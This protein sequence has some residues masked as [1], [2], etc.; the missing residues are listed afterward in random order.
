L[1]APVYAIDSIVRS[2]VVDVT[3]PRR[4]RSRCRRRRWGASRS[5]RWSSA[6]PSD[7][8]ATLREENRRLRE[9]IARLRAERGE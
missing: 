4:R 9:Q 3:R 6:A 5:C 8:L 1:A 7:E 2:R